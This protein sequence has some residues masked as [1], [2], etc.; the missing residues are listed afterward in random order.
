M[1]FYEQKEKVS[2][3]VES[4]EELTNKLSNALA[5]CLEEMENFE[6]DVYYDPREY[7]RLHR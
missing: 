2:S 4:Y 7:N 5:V 1:Q 6:T 3:N